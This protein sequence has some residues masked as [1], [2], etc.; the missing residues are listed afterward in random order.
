MCLGTIT[1]VEA[2]WVEGGARLGRLSDG[3][4]VPL[5]YVPGAAAGSVVL[6]HLGIPVEVLEPEVAADA[7][8][9]RRE[10]EST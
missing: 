4:V 1:R 5:T 9:L 6:V 10:K 3:S 2:A 8:H 7:L